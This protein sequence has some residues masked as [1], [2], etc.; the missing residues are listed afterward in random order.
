MYRIDGVSGSFLDTGIART[1]ATHTASIYL[2]T[3]GTVEFILDGTLVGS[4]SS[5]QWGIP[6]LSDVVLTA[7]G[8][9]S[10][11]EAIFTSFQSSVPE[12][13]YLPCM[14][15][16][17]FISVFARILKRRPGHNTNT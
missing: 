1:D 13:S 2:E 8:S 3:D 15:A 10:G 9:A 14:A 5:A 11:Q 4:A 12:P 16:G 6:A 7:N 17:M